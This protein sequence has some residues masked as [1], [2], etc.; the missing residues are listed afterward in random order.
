MT[1]Y[2]DPLPSELG[3]LTLTATDAGLSGVYLPGHRHGPPSRAGWVH[4]AERLDAARTQLAEYLAG[5]RTAFDLALAPAAG[6]PFQLRVWAALET[7]GYGETLSYAQLAD[8]LGTPAAVRA[9]GAA[10]GRNPLS[11]VR[12]CHRVIGAD[13]SLTGY[14]GGLPAKRWLLALEAGTLAFAL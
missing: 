12:P 3:E 13:G 2:F 11:I 5:T 1:T 7:I 6:T 10:N 4:H 14:G 8:R 9:V